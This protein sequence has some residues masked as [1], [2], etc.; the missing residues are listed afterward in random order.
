VRPFRRTQALNILL[1]FV[2]NRQLHE[3]YPAQKLVVFRKTL[4]SLLPE[5][6]RAGRAKPH[7]LLSL[8]TILRCLKQHQS[9]PADLDWRQV[10]EQLLRFAQSFPLG[11]QTGPVKKSFKKLLAFLDVKVG[12]AG[13]PTPREESAG[14]REAAAESAA[15]PAA[16]PAAQPAS[17]QD[18]QT[19]KKKKKKKNKEALMRKKEKKMKS[20]AAQ[21]EEE[22]PSF[23]SF[24]VDST[25][26][27][28]NPEDERKFKPKKNKKRQISESIAESPSLGKKTKSKK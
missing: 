17:E 9:A 11:K 28:V 23:A 8:F 16:E 26:V 27:L 21:A 1:A 5:L 25:E 12:G 6:E 18:T 19:E 3:L 2:N 15:Q 4:A 7:H 24:L 13:A 22:V 10:R 14:P 20:A